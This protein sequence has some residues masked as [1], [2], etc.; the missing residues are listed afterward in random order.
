MCNNIL[1]KCK[2]L[3]DNVIFTLCVLLE[4]GVKNK[5]SVEV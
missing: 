5:E 4:F 1:K 3:V 2:A